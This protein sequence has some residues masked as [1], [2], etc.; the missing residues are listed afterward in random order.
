MKWGAIIFYSLTPHKYKSRTAIATIYLK[1]VMVNR[2]EKR[3][4]KERERERKRKD[5]DKKRIT[6]KKER[7]KGG[8]GRERVRKKRWYLQKKV[9]KT[10]L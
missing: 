1:K 6:S 4:D 3:K 8:R 7:A 10:R 2:R 9:R 5:G